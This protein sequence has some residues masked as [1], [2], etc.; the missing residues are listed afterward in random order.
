MFHTLY[1]RACGTRSCIIA[2][3]SP[4][5]LATFSSWC[6]IVGPEGMSPKYFSTRALASAAVTSPAITSTALAAPYQ[7]R[8]HSFTS[9]RGRVEI[10]HRSDGFP[11]IRMARGIGVLRDDFGGL[12]VG[13]ILALALLV[14][15]HAALLV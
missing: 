15:H 7:V 10:F 12:A 3:R 14:L 11:G 13:L 9:S 1:M 2:R 6:R 5:I 8:N 4:V